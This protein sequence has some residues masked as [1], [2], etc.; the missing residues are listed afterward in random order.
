MRSPDIGFASA[1]LLLSGIIWA[2]LSLLW[3][4]FVKL[5]FPPL[6]LFQ[7]GIVIF[8]LGF[9]V[10]VWL[11]CRGRVETMPYLSFL[12]VYLTFH[13][14]LVLPAIWDSEALLTQGSIF[15]WYFSGDY[16]REALSVAMA[17]FA[18]LVAAL[19]VSRSSREATAVTGSIVAN[20]GTR[21]D[22]LFAGAL[23][24]LC[25]AWLIIVLVALGIGNYARYNAIARGGQIGLLGDFITLSYPLIALTFFLGVQYSKD[26]R[27]LMTIFGFWGGIAFVIGLRGEVLFP[28]AMVLPILVVQRRIRFRP[29][30][31]IIVIISTLTVASFVREYRNNPSVSDAL[32]ETSFLSGM[33]ELG[34]SLRP[35]YETVRW[36]TTGLMDFQFGVTYVAPFERTLLRVIP[37]VDRLPAREDLRL[38]NV[39]IFEF[40]N[41]G[42]Y[43][44][45]I[46]AEAY[47]NFGVTGA[48]AVGLMV[49]LVMLRFGRDIARGASSLVI[50][51]L[52]YALFYHIRQSFVGAFGSFVIF[53][54]VGTLL[55]TFVRRRALGSRRHSTVGA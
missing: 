39:A 37:L 32:E 1:N 23:A 15:R 43:G 40:T 38:M 9:F 11:R 45:S 30:I 13:F 10:V 47:I 51:A 20:H 52:V 49:G 16:V 41:G 46:A 28:L 42:S 27:P 55:M 50:A 18:G 25:I 6:E 26:L 33:A 36:T 17:F 44:F 19:L 22:R 5:W 12:V 21:V 8:L 2:V 14:G 34:G 7:W 48:F 35:A 29:L 3:F 31:V 24:A 54:V 53:L 4:A